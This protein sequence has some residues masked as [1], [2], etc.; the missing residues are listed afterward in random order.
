MFL[1]EMLHLFLTTNIEV[2]FFFQ[3]WHMGR[4]QLAHR[5][6]SQANSEI[7]NNA[8]LPT[9][10]HTAPEGNIRSGS[11]ER[12]KFG[13]KNF[14]WR[15]FSNASLRTGQKTGLDKIILYVSHFQFNCLKRNSGFSFFLKLFLDMESFNCTNV[16]QVVLR[17]WQGSLPKQGSSFGLP[18]YNLDKLD[19]QGRVLN[20]WVAR[21][22]SS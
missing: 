21:L 22:F 17:G 15:R 16:L 2:C 7:T 12:F 1:Q 10:W 13:R 3:L 4:L 11:L 8:S 14:R 19:I 20:A 9:C 6:L 18:A 5:K